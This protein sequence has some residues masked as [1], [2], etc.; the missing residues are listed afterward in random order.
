MLAAITTITMV[1]S[2]SR[3][4]MDMKRRT[5]ETSDVQRC[6]RSPVETCLW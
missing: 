2:I 1:L 3:S 5:V 4:C 6:T